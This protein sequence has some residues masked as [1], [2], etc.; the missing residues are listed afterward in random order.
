MRSARLL[1]RTVTAQEVM[2]SDPRSCRRCFTSINRR[3]KLRNVSRFH[4][5]IDLCFRS[6]QFCARRGMIR[7]FPFELLTSSIL[8]G[9]RAAPWWSSLETSPSLEDNLII[10]RVGAGTRRARIEGRTQTA[11][12]QS[13]CHPGGPPARADPA[14]FQK[15]WVRIQHENTPNASISPISA[16]LPLNERNDRPCGPR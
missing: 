1:L 4:C 6:R 11:R 16:R 7:K 8:A 15:V 2:Q 13:H 14:S 3:H 9:R 5:R 12:T 10:K